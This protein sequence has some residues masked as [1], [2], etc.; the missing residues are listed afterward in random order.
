MGD[1][2]LS[3]YSRLYDFM[4]GAVVRSQEFDDEFNAI[5]AASRTT[6]RAVDEVATDLPNAAARANKLL[7]FN[8]S[9]EPVVTTDIASTFS[10]NDPTSAR[11]AATKQWV[12]SL[13]VS[14]VINPRAYVRSKAANY[15]A[16]LGDIGCIIDCTGSWTLSLTASATLGDGF[17]MWVRNTGSGTITIDPDGAELIDGAASYTLNAGHYCLLLCDGSGWRVGLAG[18]VA[19]QVRNILSNNTGWVA[20]SNDE[21]VGEAV[22]HGDGVTHLFAHWT[23]SLFLLAGGASGN[24]CTSPDGTTWTL[25]TLPASMTVAALANIGNTVVMAQ[26]SST[27]AAR[28]TDGGVTWASL[29]LPASLNSPSLGVVG[30]LFVLTGSATGTTYYTSPDGLTWTSRSW[31]ESQTWTLTT[32]T[33]GGLM[34]AGASS[35]TAYYTSP[36]GLT[37]TS[38]TLPAAHTGSWHRTTYSYTTGD[39]ARYLSGVM[40]YETTDGINW[41][42][43]G[44]SPASN[45]LPFRLADGVWLCTKSGD[46]IYT[47]PSISGPWT[48]RRNATGATL[49]LG[50]RAAINSAG[51]AV[52]SNAGVGVASLISTDQTVLGLFAGA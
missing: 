8:A 1:A 35:S 49:A 14:G 21:V 19:L 48:S 10:C 31:P 46:Y 26:N 38:R 6:I 20:V 17:C 33:V 45:Y 24:I 23:G 15:T 7:A 32:G 27:A 44:D 9:G 47:G 12:E 16:V 43:P 37:W 40:I 30:G 2:T 13:A 34:L 18:I 41:S 5:A 52:T 4:A 42:S 3:I 25:R 22:G 51:I 39:V 50:Y 29:T 36:D 28:S 11:H